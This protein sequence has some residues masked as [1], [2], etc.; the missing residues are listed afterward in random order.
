MLGHRTLPRRRA[1][2][3]QQPV[4][5]RR[6]VRQ[7]LECGERLRADDEQRRGRVEIVGGGIE[8]D[9]VDVR[10]EP[11]DQP[12]LCVVR[13]CGGGHGRSEV[14][15]PDADVDYGADPLP[16]RTGPRSVADALRELAHLP[17][18]RVHV[19]DDVLTVDHERRARGHP[20]RHVQDGAV[21][22]RVDVLAG[23]H[24]IATL[25]HPG[26][27]CDR[28][29]E[30][31]RLVRDALLRVVQGEVGALR[32]EA[33]GP[34]GVRGEE[35]AQV[36]RRDLVEVRRQRLPLGCGRHVHGGQSTGRP[37]PALR[38]RGT[39]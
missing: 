37:S 7:G 19:G 6:R 29:E 35:V 22:G 9:R 18:D 34:L 17:R 36:P 4:A 1:E 39:R 31:Q 24:R 28:H 10:H 8:V 14:R 25:F 26:G 21:L 32:G 38:R 3:P 27:A 20:Q 5:G 13:Q 15:A 30:A 33:H 23:E 2:T 12:R 16:R 11:A